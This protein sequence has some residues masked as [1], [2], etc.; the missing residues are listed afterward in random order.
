MA[1]PLLAFLADENLNGGIVRGI[2]RR[3]PHL[4]LTR[5]QDIG[6]SGAIDSIVLDRAAREQRVLLTHDVRTITRFAFERVRAGLPMPG[7]VEIDAD[8][9]VGSAIEELILIAECSLDG[10]WEGRVLYLPLR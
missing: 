9:P 4:D 2:R 3:L 7:V 5:V 10:E 6:L 1:K 8:L